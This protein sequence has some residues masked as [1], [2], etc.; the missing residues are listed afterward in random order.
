MAPPNRRYLS[1]LLLYG[2][3]IAYASTVIG[4]MGL[5]FV[6]MDP[7]EAARIFAG[8]MAVWVDNASDQRADW[9]G[10]LSMFVPFGY[11]LCGVLWPGAKRGSMP[12]AGAMAGALLLAVGFLLSIKYAQLFFP[13]RTVTLNYV[14][15]QT[16]GSAAGIAAFWFAQGRLTGLR[17][18]PGPGVPG[19]DALRLWLKLYAAALCVFMLMPLDIALSP[20]DLLGQFDRLAEIVT[21]IPGEDR[22]RLVRAVLLAAGTLSTMPLGMLLVLGPRG[23]NR[24]LGAAVLRGFAWMAALLALS[25]LV[26]GAQPALIALGYRTAGIA[27]GAAGM[28]W[29]ARQDLVRLRRL[30]T[31]FAPWAVLPFIV[32]LCAVNGVL[33]SRWR[34]LDEVADTAVTRGLIPLYYYYVVTKA[35]AAKNLVAHVLMYAPI[36]GYAWL[37][38]HRPATAGLVALG[39]AVLIEGARMLRPGL[40]ADINVLAVAPL[41]A[42]LTARG[43]PAIWAMLESVAR[44]RISLTDPGTPGWRERA[45]AAQ[46]R[47]QARPAETDAVEE[48]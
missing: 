11:L 25:A 48:L 29:L 10:N 12:K 20:E 27:A 40:G 34:T 8:R 3:L 4:P 30:A 35:E 9:M 37:R 38:G 21:R 36:G 16:A 15:A 14:V 44:P 42:L 19:R 32:L 6:P 45:A 23:R 31:R 24:F 5:H 13:P 46:L 7:G 18:G 22:P 47:A 26:M 43:L 41:A 17:D 1:W 39:L 28:R 2:L 33:S